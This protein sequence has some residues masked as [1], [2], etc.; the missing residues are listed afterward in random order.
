MKRRG[1]VLLD[2]EKLR[3]LRKRLED[4]RLEEKDY[5]LLGKMIREIARLQRRR[6]WMGRAKRLLR[7]ML[8][9]KSWVRGCLG[10]RPL[11]PEERD[12]NGQ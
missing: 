10:K 1:D 2:E 12:E 3:G 6:L 4:E 9:L 11:A 8:G 7:R 5:E